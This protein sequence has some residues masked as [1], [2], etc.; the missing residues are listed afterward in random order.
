MRNIAC[1]SVLGSPQLLWAGIAD[2]GCRDTENEAR[3][4]MSGVGGDILISHARDEGAQLRVA[5]YK[6]R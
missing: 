1:G 4:A 3:E 2:G 6:Q 5:C